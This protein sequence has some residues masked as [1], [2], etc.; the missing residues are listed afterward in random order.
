MATSPEV[1]IKITGD[2]K[3]ADAAF[4]Q[5]KGS[6]NRLGGELT[7]LQAISVRALNFTGLAGGASVAS[8][9]SLAKAA[10]DTADRL[11]KLSQATGVSVK[12]LSR[13]AFAASLSGTTADELGKALGKLSTD[14]ASG[15]VKLTELGISTV[16]ASGKLKTADQIF[17]EVAT[18]FASLPDGVNKTSAA[19]ALFGDE[20]GPKLVPLLNQGAA[21]LKKL[22]DESDRFGR[23]INDDQVRRAEE[24]NDNL[25]RLQAVSQ[26]AGERL[27]ALLIPALNDLALAFLEA[28]NESEKLTADDGVTSWADKASKAVAFLVDV[29]DG[30]GRVVQIV[31][32]KIGADLAFLGRLLEGDLKGAKQVY[33]EFL[34]DADAIANERFFSDRLKSIQS[35]E[36]RAGQ[37]RVDT[38]RK[39][40]GQKAK[41]AQDLVAAQIKLDQVRKKSNQDTLTEEIKG[42]ERLRDALIKARQDSLEGAEKARGKAE[43]LKKEGETTRLEGRDK[44]QA[45]RSG[46]QPEFQKQLDISRSAEAARSQANTAA[47]GAILA[48]FQN[49]FKKAEKLSA[50]ALAAAK[51][52]E[53]F[54]DQLTNKGE[55]A[56]LVEQLAEVKADALKAQQ[57]A[58]ERQATQLEEK[59]AK[60]GAELTTQE[61]RL[62]TLKAELEKPIALTADVTAAENEVKRL[63]GELDKIKDKTVTVTINQAGPGAAAATTP[64]TGF[65]SGGYTGPGSK[66]QP[67]GVVH[68]GEFVLR[69]EVVRQAG[70]RQMLERLNRFGADA[71]RGYAD[72]GFVGGRG[73][74]SGTP[75]NLHWPDGTVSNMS[76]SRDEAEL[77]MR[78]FRKASL[79]AGGRR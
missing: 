28:L 3:G 43:E 66:F 70:M 49:D 19:V 58:Q 4:G 65:A 79:K 26:A 62:K 24:F 74:S 45:L 37:E 36:V 72:G 78:V 31:G 11:G 60:Q 15:G 76:A 59:A 52:S 51:R 39:F 33:S 9:L 54:A 44:A 53:A 77:V 61:E 57:I 32:K 50:D 1:K 6:L 35:A 14:A 41:I 12:E 22:A 18:R 67:A 2:A 29:F 7:K 13:L 25:T 73:S 71:V 63:Q 48:A 69:Q 47:Q 55:A 64:A 38:E 10:A 46:D 34:S 56:N 42:V 75:I 20:L 21:G 8:V 30:F 68:A 27:G 40:A 17:Q 16:D 23:T 5:I